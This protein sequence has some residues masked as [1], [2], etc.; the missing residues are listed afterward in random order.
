MQ[1]RLFRKGLVIG[2]IVLLIGLA[3]IPSFN[4]VTISRD[5]EETNLVVDDIEKDCYEC[6]FNSKTHLAEKILGR[7][8]KNELFKD[9]INQYNSDDDRPI[10]S[11]LYDIWNNLLS[12]YFSLKQLADTFPEDSIRKDILD[13]T[14]HIILVYFYLQIKDIW[15]FTF[16]CSE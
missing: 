16:N 5:I 9:V 10:C 8:E 15:A 3:F 1:E 4:A 2:I 7:L 12:L 13:E 11:F 14:A 6:Q